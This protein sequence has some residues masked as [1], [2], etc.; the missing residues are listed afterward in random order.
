MDTPDGYRTRMLFTPRPPHLTWATLVAL[1]PQLAALLAEAQ[2]TRDSGTD[3]YFC[4]SAVWF[5]HDGHR[6]LKP[7]RVRLPVT[8]VSGHLAALVPAALP[9][10]R[11]GVHRRWRMR[12]RD[13]SDCLSRAVPA[14][15]PPRG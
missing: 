5:G 14:A 9:R 7:G 12:R 1:E 10:Q 13:R 8:D 6:G 11:N 4:A 15:L 2:A 3:P